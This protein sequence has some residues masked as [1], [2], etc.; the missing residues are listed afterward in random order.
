MS[1]KVLVCSNNFEF[2]PIKLCSF[3]SPSPISMLHGGTKWSHISDKIVRGKGRLES[4]LL[5]MNYKIF[6]H[7]VECR[8]VD[9][10]LSEAYHLLL[11]LIIG[12]EP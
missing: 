8:I 12:F 6:L 5:E 4:N 7:Y 1:G 10:K 3:I 2:F 11:P 9:H